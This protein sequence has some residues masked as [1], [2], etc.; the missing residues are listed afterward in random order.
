MKMPTILKKI[1]SAAITGFY[2]AEDSV[3]KAL[4]NLRCKLLRKRLVNKSPTII[5]V[6]CIGGV[7]YH[8]LGLR[9]NSPTINLYFSNEDFFNF[10][11]DLQ[12]FL[13]TELI[14]VSE[15]KEDFP[16]GRLEYNGKKVDVFFMHYETFEDA[17]NKWDER[18]KRVDFTNIYIMHMITE[19]RESDI[20]RFEKL[21]FKNKMMIANANPCNSKYVY[22]HKVFSREDYK[23]GQ[24]LHFKS[25]R[26]IK[27]YLDDINYVRFLNCGVDR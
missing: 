13:E 17:K 15:A 27:R 18:K 4:R 3:V 23:T 21:P 6:N 25:K 16:V 5:S 19:V 8:N 14:E 12:G 2:N 10:V 24:I 22:T 20:E 9:F 11:E 7:I 26:S 1:T